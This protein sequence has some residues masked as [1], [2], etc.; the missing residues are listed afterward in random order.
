MIIW[1]RLHFSAFFVVRLS[2]VT[3]LQ[4]ESRSSE[5]HFGDMSFKGRGMLLY[6]PFYSSSILLFFCLEYKCDGWSWS[7]HLG[8][9]RWGHARFGRAMDGSLVPM[10]FQNRAAYPPDSNGKEEESFF[11]FLIQLFCVSVPNLNWNRCLFWG[12]DF[13]ALWASV[14]I[15]R[16]IMFVKAQWKLLSIMKM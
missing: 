5:C 10:I 14:G 9:W 4:S 13:G 15:M 8:S 6:P 11:I 1:N 12:K 7:C 2:H 16:I 3:K